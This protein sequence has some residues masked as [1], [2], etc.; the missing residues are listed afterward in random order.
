MVPEINL[1]GGNFRVRH[2]FQSLVMFPPLVQSLDLYNS[3]I[4]LALQLFTA[5]VPGLG[6]QATE[7]ESRIWVRYSHFSY[8]ILPS[9]AKMG[10]LVIHLLKLG[11][12]QPA[13]SC[14]AMWESLETAFLITC[15]V[16]LL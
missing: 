6:N 14:W 9:V 16:I 2:R 13:F 15:T 8:C 12:Y 5:S 3:C 1:L 7:Q 11:Y 4:L 10:F